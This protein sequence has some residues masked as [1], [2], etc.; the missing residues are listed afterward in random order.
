VEDPDEALGRTLH[1][2]ATELSHL[3]KISN[4][5]RR[6]SKQAR[7]ARADEFQIKNDDGDN[8][9]DLLLRQFVHYI[10]DRFPNISETLRQRLSRTM[11]LR[12]RMILYRRRRQEKLAAQPQKAVLGLAIGPPVGGNTEH[13]AQTVL[14]EVSHPSPDMVATR[15]TP[16]QIRSATTLLQDKFN[17]AVL[18]PSVVSASKTMPFNK[19]ENLRFPPAPGYA[20]RQRY[21]RLRGRRLA[22]NQSRIDHE[23]V[24]GRARLE[25]TSEFLQR[26]GEI[27]C[28]YCLDALPA[29][30]AFEEPRWR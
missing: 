30:E 21:E 12:R 13:A 8:V 26:I 3:N 15:S 7:D 28:P 23:T 11:L 14:Q 29:K 10:Q 22:A 4:V 2:I 9:E 27:T 18:S 16:S 5:I 1:D 24:L 20:A 6:A 19:H 25:E 17:S